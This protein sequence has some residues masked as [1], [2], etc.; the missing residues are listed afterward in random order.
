MS[1]GQSNKQT[2]NMLIGEKGSS[3]LLVVL[4]FLAC[5]IAASASAAAADGNDAADNNRSNDSTHARLVKMERI[6]KQMVD[7]SR[8]ERHHLLGSSG[9][10]TGGK[11]FSSPALQTEALKEQARERMADK[12]SKVFEETRQSYLA[13]KRAKELAAAQEHA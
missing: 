13:R 2:P 5:S 4:L 9:A 3:R 10:T 8:V 12:L 6:R 7:S 11:V 1:E